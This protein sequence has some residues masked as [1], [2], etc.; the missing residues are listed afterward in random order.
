MAVQDGREEKTPMF[1]RAPLSQGLDQS[2]FLA[3]DRASGVHS[4]P[5]SQASPHFTR[6][7]VRLADDAGLKKA[8][9]VFD[10]TPK[11]VRDLD[12]SSCVSDSLRPTSAPVP[13]TQ[14]NINPWVPQRR[15][16]PF[17]KTREKSQFASTG[18]PLP[19]Q[20][21]LETQKAITTEEI[22][23]RN[24]NPPTLA[25]SQIYNREHAQSESTRLLEYPSLTLESNL[26][27]AQGLG[28]S[29]TMTGFADEQS[30]LAVMTVQSST[31]PSPQ[32]K[33]IAS[34]KR[35]RETSTMEAMSV[36]KQAKM[37]DHST[38][39][40][41]LSGRDDTAPLT[42]VSSNE[43]LVTTIAGGTSSQPP[44]TFMNEIDEFVSKHK[45]RPAPQEIW[46]RSGYFEATPEERQSIISDFIC[47]S[48][49]SEDF[50]RI[51]EDTA[52]AWRRIGLGD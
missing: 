30:P 38:Q 10:T 29:L 35:V 43:R 9:S 22:E 21:V 26:E 39:T 15:E 44:Q 46:L 24:G 50:I 19:H 5:T 49:D 33:E 31:A 47:E 6:A 20:P 34:N 25:Q 42:S 11:L 32:P 4:F 1:S 3:R 14:D 40:Q 18:L 23:T 41:T 37:V 27:G 51:C 52:C 12:T 17:P 2:Q 13:G 36:N 45:S 48:L 8:F 28:A 16:L 7:S